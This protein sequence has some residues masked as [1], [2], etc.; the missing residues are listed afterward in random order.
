MEIT[1]KKNKEMHYHLGW[2]FGTVMSFILTYLAMVTLNGFVAFCAIF[3][4]L[5]TGGYYLTKMVRLWMGKKD[6]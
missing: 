2:L 1:I 6:S 5:M 4:A 3:S